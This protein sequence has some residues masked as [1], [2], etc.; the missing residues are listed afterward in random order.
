MKIVSRRRLR[1]S[2]SVEGLGPE[3]GRRFTPKLYKKE[4][5]LETNLFFNLN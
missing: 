5:S 4:L 1:L 2:Y 3:P